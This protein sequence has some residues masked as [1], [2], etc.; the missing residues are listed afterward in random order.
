MSP[1]PAAACPLRFVETRPTRRSSDGDCRSPSLGGRV[2]VRSP[3]SGNDCD[4][5]R[6]MSRQLLSPGLMP[7]PTLAVGLLPLALALALALAVTLSL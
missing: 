5:P 7:N 4:T 3:L 1:V 2:S 6:R